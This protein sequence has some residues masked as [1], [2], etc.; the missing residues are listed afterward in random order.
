MCPGGINTAHPLCS[1]IHRAPSVG[2]S[3]PTRVG[4]G[5]VREGSRGGRPTSHLSNGVHEAMM[6]GGGGSCPRWRSA[7][8]HGT[9]G[10]GLLNPQSGREAL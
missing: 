1:W 5:S 9:W 8:A 2:G 6:R 7:R 10:R 3:V 4:G